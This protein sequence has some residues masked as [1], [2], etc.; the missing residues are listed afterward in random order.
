[1]SNLLDKNGQWL[2][3]IVGSKNIKEYA[4]LPL[5]EIQRRSLTLAD[6]EKKKQCVL[7]QILHS[8]PKVLLNYCENPIE[9][10]LGNNW[11][12]VDQG[13]WVIPQHVDVS[14]VHKWL[15]LGNWLLYV[16]KQVVSIK[17]LRNY[18]FRNPTAFI[19]MMK[20]TSMSF[21]VCSFYDNDPWFIGVNM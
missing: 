17:M 5:W 16:S 15:Y 10:G 20:Q 11:V 7:G 18:D 21:A 6:Y 8:F 9:N 13:T 2:A 1:M 3:N 12:E 19:Q 14:E 4:Q